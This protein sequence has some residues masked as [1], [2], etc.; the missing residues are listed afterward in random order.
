M[1]VYE[2]RTGTTAWWAALTLALAVACGGSPDT[3]QGEGIVRGVDRDTGRV[4]LDH[5]TIPGMMQAMRM[6][7]AVADAALLAE[8]EP[9]DEVRFEVHEADGTYTITTL[10]VLEPEGSE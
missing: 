10:E 4:T 1:T 6:D 2:N 8:L 5:G 9:G 7:F 3:R